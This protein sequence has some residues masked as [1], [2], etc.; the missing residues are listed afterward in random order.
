M[1]YHTTN[2]IANCMVIVLFPPVN[3]LEFNLTL[4]GHLPVRN[5]RSTTTRMVSRAQMVSSRLNL[6]L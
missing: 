3:T 6:N 2:N 4:L 1:G 5:G